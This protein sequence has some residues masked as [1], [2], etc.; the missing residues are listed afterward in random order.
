MINC[1]ECGM[2][3]SNNTIKKHYIN[4]RCC[5]DKYKYL[6]EFSIK[7]VFRAIIGLNDGVTLNELDEFIRNEII[8]EDEFQRHLSEFIFKSGREMISFAKGTNNKWINTENENI[9][10]YLNWI[11]E[12]DD[13]KNKT[14]FSTKLNIEELHLLEEN[15]FTYLYDFTKDVT[16]N[17][18][19]HKINNNVRIEDKIKILCYLEK[20]SIIDHIENHD[21]NRFMQLCNTNPEIMNMAVLIGNLSLRR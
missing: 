15:K 3:L 2:K 17:I 14:H 21:D 6:M 12:D 10:E 5:N 4:S 11:D 19:V 13:E 9:Y 18:I 8:K 16:I 7:D 20:S 1:I